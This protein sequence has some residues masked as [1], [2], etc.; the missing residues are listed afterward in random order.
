MGSAPTEAGRRD[1][2]TQHEVSL[3]EFWIQSTEVTQGQWLAVMGH[4][5]AFYPINPENPV[6]MV[7]WHDAARFVAL[8]NARGEGRYRL[9]SE[10]EWEYAARAGSGSAYAC[11][12][13]GSACL[14]N[15]AWL[16]E[17]TGGTRSQA[18]ATKSPNAWGLYDLHGNVSEWV[19]DWYGPY[20]EASQQQPTGPAFG[21]LKVNRG[22]SWGGQALGLR[23]AQR[24]AHDPNALSSKL[25]FRVVFEP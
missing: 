21:S 18:V 14:A 19:N 22:G 25:G 4:N 1:D 11:G 20:S 12:E 8:L 5:P 6:E 10:A 24:T 17:N 13:I 3:A 15:M 7:S 2:E 23:A 16:I 9:P